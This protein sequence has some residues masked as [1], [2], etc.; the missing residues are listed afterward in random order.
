MLFAR[1]SPVGS[2][3]A[4]EASDAIKVAPQQAWR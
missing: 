2:D 3:C 1:A 4:V